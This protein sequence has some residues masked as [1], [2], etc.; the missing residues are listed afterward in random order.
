MTA[1]DELDV[2]KEHTWR[3]RRTEQAVEILAAKVAKGSSAGKAK[4]KPKD[5]A[6]AKTKTSRKPAKNAK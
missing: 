1:L 5:K 2:G 6:K 4:A 3:G